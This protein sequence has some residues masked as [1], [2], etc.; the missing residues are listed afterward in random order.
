M[1]KLLVF[2]LACMLLLSTAAFAAS[3]EPAAD[4]TCSHAR[5]E[6]VIVKEA[7]C[8]EKGEKEL[9]CL[10]CG[11]TIQTVVTPAT[12][13]NYVKSVVAATCTEAGYTQEQCVNCGD[14]YAVKGTE[15]P[16]LGHEFTEVVVEAACAHD[17][18]VTRT[19]N[20][21]G[22]V[23]QDTIL[24]LE[25]QYV[26]QNDSV[27]GQ[28]GSII[29]YGT[30]ICSVC[31]GITGASAEDYAAVA[32]PA[33]PAASGEPSGE[34]SAEPSGEASAEPA[35]EAATVMNPDYDPN[36]YNWSSMCLILVVVIVAVGPILMLSFGKK[37]PDEVHTDPLN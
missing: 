2:V 6:E 35:A 36:S 20:R 22:L 16:A 32:V 30:K 19:C 4:T 5:L 26:Y 28:D 7:S 3:A 8:E 18:S 23:E 25:H 29:S 13:H 15:T 34:A 9:V 33:A 12:G 10:D 27:T 1:K 14:S 11:K 24:A 37:K 31:G 21:C 17:G